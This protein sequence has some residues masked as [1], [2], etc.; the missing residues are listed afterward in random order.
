MRDEFVVTSYYLV[1]VTIQ[2]QEDSIFQ[3]TCMVWSAWR[4]EMLVTIKLL[5]RSKKPGSEAMDDH[6]CKVV[7]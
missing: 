7:S 3:K 4:V 6:A 1:G 5:L 2:Q